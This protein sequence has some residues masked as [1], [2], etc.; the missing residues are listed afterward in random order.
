MQIENK[1]TKQRFDPCLS[2][3]RVDFG[4]MLDLEYADFDKNQERDRAPPKAI[5]TTIATSHLYRIL[6]VAHIYI[7]TF[8]GVYC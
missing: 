3:F 1:T 6:T 4:F 7:Y 2:L 8:V 5:I